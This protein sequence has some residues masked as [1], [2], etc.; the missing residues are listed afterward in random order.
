M[1]NNRGRKC[2]RR[3]VDGGDGRRFWPEMSPERGGRRCRATIE[4]ENVA[5]E[6]WVEV[7]GDDFG[8]KCRRKGVGGGVG[9]Q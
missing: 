1:G 4:A 5:E 9:Q 8:L 3:G 2:R 6:G 7:M